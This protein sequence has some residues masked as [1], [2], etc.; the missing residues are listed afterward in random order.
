[1]RS[2]L[3]AMTFGQQVFGEDAAAMVR[4]FWA[5]GGQE[6]DTAYVYNGGE[7]ERIVGEILEGLEASFFVA[8]KVNPRVTGRLDYESMKEQLVSSLHRLK[9]QS[10]DILYLHFPDPTTS[11]DETLS[12]CA[13]LHEE[14]LFDELGLSNYSLKDVKIINERASELDCPPPTVYEGLYNALSRNVEE[15]L[16]PYLSSAGIRF[17]AYNPLAG[18]LL[19]NKY[20]S[21]TDVPRDGRFV[22]R[23]GYRSRYWND[24]YFEALGVITSAC[25]KFDIPVAEAAY[26]WLAFH[27]CLSDESND[28]IIVGASSLVQLERNLRALELVELPREVVTAIDDGWRIVQKCAPEYH[29]LAVEPKGAQ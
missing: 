15:E 29:R 23:P 8:T 28:G 13:R 17:Y 14:G 22:L 1:M 24:T 11:I 21:V 5:R 10:V 2:I 27:S 25:E 26:R 12:A 16:M 9:R 20:S 18:G 7:S 3:G 4:E 19:T 6:I